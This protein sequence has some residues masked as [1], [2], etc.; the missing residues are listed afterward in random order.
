MDEFANVV[1]EV[2]PPELELMF[3]GKRIKFSDLATEAIALAVQDGFTL[4]PR[5]DYAR[6]TT[7]AEGEGYIVFR[8]DQSFYAWDTKVLRLL[9]IRKWPIPDPPSCDAFTSTS[10]SVFGCWR[11]VGSPDLSATVLRRM[12]PLL[13]RPD[14][15]GVFQRENGDKPFTWKLAQVRGRLTFVVEG[16]VGTLRYV[17]AELRDHQLTLAGPNSDVLVTYERE[18]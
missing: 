8:V 18:S 10:P 14:G 13:I 1:W 17:V 3:A 4:A 9:Q 6:G 7:V 5:I 11:P 2:S 12:K 16:H 15:T